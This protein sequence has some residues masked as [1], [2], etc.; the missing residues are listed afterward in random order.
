MIVDRDAA[1]AKALVDEACRKSA[2]LWLRPAG[3]DRAQAVWHGYVDGAVHVVS[4]G[5][6]QG[7]SRPPDGAEVDVTVRSKDT[8]GRAAHLPGEGVDGCRRTTTRGTPP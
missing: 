6:E 5:L 7:P 1:L 2:M 8:G 4:G 3:S